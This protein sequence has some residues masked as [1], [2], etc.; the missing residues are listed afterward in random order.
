MRLNLLQRNSLKTR[1]TL[2][3]LLIFLVSLWT[4]GFMVIHSLRDDMQKVLGA[5]QYAIA[6]LMAADIDDQ[7]NG[8]IIALRRIAQVIE[9]ANIDTPDNLQKIL[10][11]LPIFQNLFNGGTFITDINGVAIASLP[12]NLERIGVSFI[13]RDYI[14]NTLRDG[15]TTIGRPVIGRQLKTPIFGIG[16]PIKDKNGNV[17]AVLAGVINLS[18]ANF[19]DRIE[20]NYVSESGSYML[21]DAMHRVIVA[22]S[23]KK[24]MMEFL[25]GPSIN[26]TL[27]KFIKGFEG[28][29]VFI[30]PRGFEVISGVKHLKNTNWY[31]AVVLPTEIAFAPIKMMERR[32]LIVTLLLTF[33]CGSLTW[34]VLVRQLRPL[35]VT[36]NK[37]AQLANP[38]SVLESLPVH[39]RDEIGQ[40]ITGFNRLLFELRARQEHLKES[41]ERYRT[42]FRTS[43][44]AVSITRLSDGKFLDTND[45][46]TK[47]LGWERNE[48][49]NKTSLDIGIWASPA[50]RDVFINMLKA[51]GSCE[52]LETRFVSNSGRI[53]YALVSANTITLNGEV[54]VL[55]VTQDITSK[56]NAS[57]QIEFLEYFDLLTGIPNLRLLT[58]RLNLALEEHK[59]L[60]YQGA[61]LHVDLNDFKTLNDSYGHDKGDLWLKEVAKR[62]SETIPE[63]SFLARISGD[64]FAILLSNLSIAP[65][66]AASS[67]QASA[68]QI[69]DVIHQPF[70]FNN[71]EYFS[72]CC[73]GIALFDHQQNDGNV[74]LKHAELAM[75]QAKKYGRGVLRFFDPAMQEFVS[76]RVG[77]EA[78]LRESL[79]KEDFVLYYQGQINSHKRLALWVHDSENSHLTI[80]VN[81]SATQFKQDNYAEQVLDLLTKTGAPGNRLKLEL[82]EST[83]VSELESIVNIMTILKSH[84]IGFSLDD[85]GTGFSS[86]SYLQRLPLDQLKID[87]SFIKN[88]ATNA[89]D[90]AI[91]QT[92]VTLGQ[93]LGLSVIAEGVE[94]EAQR[95]RLLEL[96][97]T[98]YQGYLYGKPAPID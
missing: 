10:T 59:N 48:L 89:S 20:T 17:L 53:V 73:I 97:C 31:V 61:L 68:R 69:L 98:L 57:D 87:G 66:E 51:H 39:R 14:S 38:D 49:L 47:I 36:A 77:L 25:P 32:I 50:E 37:L 75:Y 85:F 92:I 94:T 55:S 76:A 28:S 88:I 72:S 58:Q 8:R 79:K 60:Q 18:Q 40:L 30:N 16:T 82:T 90:A 11:E 71:T 84:G 4:L 83:L 21:I 33:M 56:K 86:L 19:M 26:A 52:H 80:S 74:I 78:D 7:L 62:I 91:A 9:Q 23:D 44:D 81:V 96:G 93:S 95:D 67:A 22:S 42:V 45:G 15:N 1:I 46:Y 27:D 63:G 12:V 43:P 2:F 34:W 29:E 54:C 64:K 5:Q 41:E 65:E 35:Q 13:D 24:R 70:T 3:T 6:S